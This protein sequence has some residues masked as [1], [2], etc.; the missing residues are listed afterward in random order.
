MTVLQCQ[1]LFL[2]RVL[3]YLFQLLFAQFVLSFL[4]FQEAVEFFLLLGLDVLLEFLL[5]VCKRLRLQTKRKK[6]KKKQNTLGD[7]TG[8]GESGFGQGNLICT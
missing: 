7:E 6:N 1:S 2:F 8:F 3:F 5:I 4:G